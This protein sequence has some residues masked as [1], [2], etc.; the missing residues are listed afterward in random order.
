VNAINY[1]RW[2]RP[3]EWSSLVPLW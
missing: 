1:L 3:L 2:R